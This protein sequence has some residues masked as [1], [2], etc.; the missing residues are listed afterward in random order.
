M[1]K[2][3]FL[4]SI[5]FLVSCNGNTVLD[6]YNSSFSVQTKAMETDNLSYSVNEEGALFFE[7]GAA[8]LALADSLSSLSDQEFRNWE[9]SIHFVSQRTLINDIIAELDESEGSP[10]YTSLLNK[11]A[12]FVYLDEE[13]IVSPVIKGLAYRN[14]TNEQG[15]FLYQ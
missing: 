10:S 13:G 6:E 12:G 4:L 9:Q 5:C 1:I 2:L 8:F 15:V 3:I 11:Y 7:S 14:I